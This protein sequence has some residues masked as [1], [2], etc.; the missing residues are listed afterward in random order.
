VLKNKS[1]VQKVKKYFPVGGRNMAN[2]AGLLN[3]WRLITHH[4]R[5]EDFLQ[6]AKNEGRLAVGWSDIGDIMQHSYDTPEKI[7]Q[8]IRREMPHLRN[9]HLGGPS[10]WR[11]CYKVELK[12]LVILST[13]KRRGCVMK[14]KDGYFYEDAREGTLSE[15]YQ[16]QRRAEAVPEDAGELWERAG[17]LAVGENIRWTFVKCLRAVEA[18][19]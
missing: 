5:Q 12:D 10:L 13:G 17:G 2:P 14:V 15:D 1:C 16:H 19:G 11:F 4:E 8:A 18:P 6:M 9:A 7:A 3:V